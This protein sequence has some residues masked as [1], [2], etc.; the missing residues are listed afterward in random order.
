MLVL[1]SANLRVFKGKRYYVRGE[2][3]G[4]K[5]GEEETKI[6]GKEEKEE[7]FTRRREK[8]RTFHDNIYD[9]QQGHTKRSFDI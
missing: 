9:L 2:E 4:G 3:R 6:G 8:N 5:K 7:I 1:L